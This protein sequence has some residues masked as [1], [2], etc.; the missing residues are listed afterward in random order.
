MKKR[1]VFAL[2]AI[3]IVGLLAWSL[4]L[5]S[6]EASAIRELR[7]KCDAIEIGM[8]RRQADE[9]LG[10]PAD[11]II[12]RHKT[13]FYPDGEICVEFGPDG[14]VTDKKVVIPHGDH[15]GTVRRMLGS[16]TTMP[17]PP[18]IM[19][20][21]ETMQDFMEDIRKGDLKSAYTLTTPAFQ[22]RYT[23]DKLRDVIA[24]YPLLDK[25]NSQGYDTSGPGPGPFPPG[26]PVKLPLTLYDDKNSLSLTLTLKRRGM[27]WEVDDM[28]V[29]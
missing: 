22:A 19:L 27:F 3:A 15:V 4:W 13:W 6:R 8:T 25:S 11:T 24:R 1:Y 28:T 20:I 12:H 9:L 2:F 21:Q 14:R 5:M 23:P 17:P 7:A 29:P 26:Q 10:R 18:V 16:E